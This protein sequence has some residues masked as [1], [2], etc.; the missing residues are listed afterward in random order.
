MKE[1]KDWLPWVPIEVRRGYEERGVQQ[2]FDWQF[3]IINESRS[4]GDQKTGWLLTDD[5]N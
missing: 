5:E 1:M 4:K 3:D 2:L